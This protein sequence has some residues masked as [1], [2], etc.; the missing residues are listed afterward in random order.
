MVKKRVWDLSI[1]GLLKDAP[2]PRIDDL[3]WAAAEK[4]KLD[5]F[6]IGLAVT[7]GCQIPLSYHPVPDIA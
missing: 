1:D 6:M 5:P 2:S 7:K 4:H 3:G